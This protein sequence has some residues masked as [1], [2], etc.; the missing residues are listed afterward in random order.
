MV[1]RQINLESHTVLKHLL[2]P[3]GVESIYYST[4]NLFCKHYLL[5]RVN[6]LLLDLTC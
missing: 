4:K 5:R 3:R 2:Q 6:D 1:T